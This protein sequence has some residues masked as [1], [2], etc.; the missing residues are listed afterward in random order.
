MMQFRLK[1]GLK[2]GVATAST[3]IEG[4]ENNSNWNYWYKQGK[5]K[6][7]SNPARANNHYELFKEDADLMAS[8]NIECYRMSIEWARLEPRQGI[9]DEEVFAHYREEIQY[10]QSKGIEVLLTIYHFSHP[11]WFEE[12]GGFENKKSP[13]IFEAFVRKV[14]SELGDLVDRFVTVNEPNVYATSAYYFGEFP[15]GKKSVISTIKVMSNLAASHIRAYNVIH[16]MLKHKDIYV[17]YASHIRV[18][19]P[20]N[21]KKL[22]DRIG[23]RLMEKMFQGGIDE[24][25]MTGKRKFPLFS[26]KEFRMGKYYD[27]IGI[28]YYARSMVSGFTEMAKP[29]APHNDMGWEIYPEGIRRVTEEYYNRFKAPIYITE[30][31]T[32]DRN[33]SFRAQFIYDHLKKITESS[34]DIRRY[35][36]WTFIDNFEWMD[37]EHERFGLVGLDYDTQERKVRQS[38]YMYS[39]VIK[40]HG[41]TEEI[42]MRYLNK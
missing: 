14:I 5:I 13:L 16:D 6:D 38:A 10:L 22:S 24:T 27:F 35:Y 39:E 32:P 15:P 21:N 8:L 34:A 12:L 31:G 7:G 33:D 1:D 11:M 30:N 9:Y 18:F 2:L 4:G 36:H 28:N 20:M 41:F 23:A 25:A 40:E 3:Q 37:G 26:R 19:E 42:A 17:G 29:D